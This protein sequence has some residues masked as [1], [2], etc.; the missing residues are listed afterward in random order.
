MV[1]AFIE[2]EGVDR[3]YAQF[4]IAVVEWSTLY[5]SDAQR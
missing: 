1:G 4:F 3:E 2:F 5:A